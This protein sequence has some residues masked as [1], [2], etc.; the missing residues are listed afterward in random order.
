[1]MPQQK[2]E[3]NLPFVEDWATK[4]RL[5]IADETIN[6][7]TTLAEYRQSV[8]MFGSAAKGIRKAWQ[9]FKKKNVRRKRLS[10]CSV[11]AAE[12]VYS[13]GVSPLLS[14]VY[15]SVEALKLRLEHPVFRKYFTQ[16]KVVSQGNYENVDWD[17]KYSAKHSRRTTVYVEFDLE[18]ALFNYGWQNPLSLGWELV[19][20]S[21]VIDW[22]LPIGDYLA[23]LD[24][25][26]ATGTIRV[27]HVMK[28]VYGSRF[29]R[30]LNYSTGL[31][32]QKPGFYKYTSH[33][34]TVQNN[35]PLPALPKWSP[36]TSYRSL[37]N[38]MALL[39]QT[40]GC[41]GYTPV[42]RKS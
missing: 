20:Y 24:A 18:K 13:F 39:T 28:F 41:K 4:I 21:F 12:L 9:L 35:I 14:D 15:D 11:A 32:F 22:M 38:A 27:A 5:E 7:G 30:K 36:S 26:R 25:L 34:R 17:G 40:R 23:S 10:T 19:P 6:L 8:S 29:F 1:M 37:L 2:Y 31:E 33:E 42:F 3:S 16:E